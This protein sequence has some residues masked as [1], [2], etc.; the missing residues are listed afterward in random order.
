MDYYAAK[1]LLVVSKMKIIG[2]FLDED[3]RVYVSNCVVEVN[4]IDAFRE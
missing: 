1:W 3:K 2:L 4:V